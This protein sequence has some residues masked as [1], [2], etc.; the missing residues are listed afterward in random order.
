MDENA[1]DDCL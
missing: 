1:D